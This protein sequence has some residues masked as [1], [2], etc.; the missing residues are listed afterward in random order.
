[1]KLVLIASAILAVALAFD[2]DGQAGQDHHRGHEEH[3]S[4]LRMHPLY[5]TTSWD[6]LEEMYLYHYAIRYFHKAP[7]L[8]FNRTLT[9]YARLKALILAWYDGD[10]KEDPGD[11]RFGENVHWADTKDQEDKEVDAATIMEDW[12]FDQEPQWD[13]NTSLVSKATQE[14]TQ[15]VWNAT[16]RFGCGQAVSEG[17]KGGTWTVCYYDPPGNVEGAERENVFA[18]D[19][20]ADEDE[21]ATEPEPETADNNG[22]EE[23][24]KEAVRALV[25]NQQTRGM[26]LDKSGGHISRL[27]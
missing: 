22:A 6:L 25:R 3:D 26:R 20:P 7:G 19:Y 16:T 11:I 4:N 9:D 17:P 24:K 2:H 23:E 8:R 5:E 27:V 1:M 21:T 13:Y 14:F 10:V 18:P 15:I 12:Y